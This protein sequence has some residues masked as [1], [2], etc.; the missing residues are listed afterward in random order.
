MN[1]I[2][3][4]KHGM[5]KL[6]EAQVIDIR[7]R[8]TQCEPQRLIAARYGVTHPTIGRINRGETWGSL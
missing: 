5:A 4:E 8:L 7:H 2:S 1:W 3:G 6:T